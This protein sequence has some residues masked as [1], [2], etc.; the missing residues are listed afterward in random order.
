MYTRFVTCGVTVGMEMI[1][2]LYFHEPIKLTSTR[3]VDIHNNFPCLRWR[4][5]IRLA[6]MKKSAAKHNSTVRMHVKRASN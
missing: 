3:Y 6:K 1:A 2:Q 4:I 5:S